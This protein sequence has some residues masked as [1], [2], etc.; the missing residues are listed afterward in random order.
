M[1]RAA[2]NNGAATNDVAASNE[3]KTADQRAPRLDHRGR[4]IPMQYLP[5]INEQGH[6]DPSRLPKD[7]LVD[8]SDGKNR[9]TPPRHYLKPLWRQFWFLFDHP[10]GDPVRLRPVV[11]HHESGYALVRVEVIDT[12]V[13]EFLTKADG[14][15]VLVPDENG[16]PRPVPNPAFTIAVDW[17]IW[18]KGRVPH[19][20]SAITGGIGRVLARIGYGTECANDV[21]LDDVIVDTP[22]DMSRRDT[23]ATPNQS[24]RQQ[25]TQPAAQP[26]AAQSTPTDDRSK[27][28]MDLLAFMRDTLALDKEQRAAMIGEVVPSMFPDKKKDEL[29]LAEIAA[30]KIAI[31]A[32]VQNPD[33]SE[34]EDALPDDTDLNDLQ[35]IR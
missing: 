28:W 19:L 6:F 30:L 15:L 17:K 29:T 1:A 33:E 21:E 24:S 23:R 35:N 20:E 22:I 9:N 2:A 34:E 4:I 7:D 31:A 26:A 11:E 10:A 5:Y 32:R 3:A 25:S 18:P 12:S 27:A 16:V 14:D 8:R 13:P